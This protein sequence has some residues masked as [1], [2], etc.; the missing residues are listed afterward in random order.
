MVF[1][2]LVVGVGFTGCGSSS[3]SKEKAKPKTYVEADI[4]V[5]LKDAKDNAAAATKNY[6]GKDVKV[7]NGHITNIESNANYICL[8]GTGDRYSMLQLQCYTNSNKALKEQVSTLKKEQNI[9]IYGTIK[10]VGEIMVYSVDI[11]KIEAK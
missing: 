10:D 6:K 7:I 2:V 4:N 11:G 3:S 1:L 5:L 8:K 9:V